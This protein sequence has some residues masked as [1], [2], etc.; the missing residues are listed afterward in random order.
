MVLIPLRF[1]EAGQMTEDSGTQVLGV[2]T[3]ADQVKTPTAVPTS[4]LEEPYNTIENNSGCV[5]KVEVDVAWASL[6]AKIV[7][8][9]VDQN[10]ALDMANK[11]VP[12]EQ[13]ICK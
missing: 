5:P 8:N 7:N 4:V 10:Q 13:N 6:K 9:E 11:L 3:A 2:T 1:V 12:L